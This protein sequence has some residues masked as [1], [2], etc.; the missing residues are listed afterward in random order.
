MRSSLDQSTVDS[1]KAKGRQVQAEG[2]H[3]K[4]LLIKINKKIRI[5]TITI[6]ASNEH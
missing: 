4:N 2:L 5:R 1:L 6:K 3:G